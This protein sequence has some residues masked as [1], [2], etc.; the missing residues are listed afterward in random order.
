MN[1]KKIKFSLLRLRILFPEFV[2]TLEKFQRFS[3]ICLKMATMYSDR[4]SPK[5]SV[6]SFANFSLW[7]VKTDSNQFLVILRQKTTPQS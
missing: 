4:M 3:Q 7:E 2:N 1:Q 6:K 5:I